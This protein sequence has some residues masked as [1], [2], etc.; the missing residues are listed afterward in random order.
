MLPVKD[1]KIP[2]STA[3]SHFSG[4]EVEDVAARRIVRQR[5]KQPGAL[6]ARGDAVRSDNVEDNVSVS[7]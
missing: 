3:V 7:N 6:N 1:L 4:N 5:D 2:G